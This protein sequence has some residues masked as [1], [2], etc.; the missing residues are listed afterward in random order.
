MFFQ[1]MSEVVATSF[2]QTETKELSDE[3]LP[4]GLATRIPDTAAI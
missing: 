3:S 2:E 4:L 1:P